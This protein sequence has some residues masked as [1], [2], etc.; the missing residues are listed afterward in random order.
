MIRLKNVSKYYSSDE[1]VTMALNN[2]NLSFNDVGFVVITGESGSGKSTLLNV[3]SGMDT[4]EDGEVYY[5]EQETSY[6]DSE[7]WD[8]YRRNNMSIIYQSYNL[9]DSY[10]ALENIEVILRMNTDLS[11]KEIRKKAYEALEKVKL[12]KQAKKRASHLSSGQ[13]QRLGIARALAKDTNVIIADEPTGNLDIEN[14]RATMEILHELSKEKL[15]LVVTHNYEQAE[16]FC[17][18]KIRLYDGKVVEDIKVNNTENIRL[19]EEKFLLGEEKNDRK[20]IFGKSVVLAGKNLMAQPHRM[21]FMFILAGFFSVASF[22]MLGTLAGATDDTMTR[23]IDTVAFKNVVKERILIKR[24]DEKEITLE[25]IETL[26]GISHIKEV[27]LYDN[28][29]DINYYYRK[30]EDYV[31]SYSYK[32]FADANKMS[33]E[34]L[35]SD[36]FVRSSY[37]I[38]EE[39][40]RSGTLPKEYNEVVMYAKDDSMLGQYIDIYFSNSK[41]GR[42]EFVCVT[43]KVTGI[44]KE[45]TEQIY[46]S[47]KLVYGLNLN[48]EKFDATLY[49]NH[50]R[51]RQYDSEDKEDYVFERE[52]KISGNFVINDELEDYEIKI[53]RNYFYELYSGDDEK[54]TEKFDENASLYA[55]ITINARNREYDEKTYDFKLS[56]SGANV[57]EDIME[58]NY[59]TFVEIT[60]GEAITQCSVYL[61]DYAYTKDALKDIEKAGYEGLSV[62]SISAMEYNEELLNQ[63]LMTLLI[64]GI[65]LVIL[66][67]LMIVVI[68]GMLRIK[69]KDLIVLRG[70]GVKKNIINKSNYCYMTILA[71]AAMSITLTALTVLSIYGV[72]TVK[73]CTKYMTAVYYMVWAVLCV[74]VNILAAVLFNR[75]LN[76]RFN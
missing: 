20:K 49:I 37:C 52:R 40:L 24:S 67:V 5:G 38:K 26:Q 70:L 19:N 44:L 35:K 60:G 28:A 25:D 29:A 68:Y 9:I 69:T 16:P 8:N 23:E 39:D 3:I 71:M 12:T 51:V 32:E 57:S 6:F 27:D 42:E 13:K 56:Q 55:S 53:S 59:D 46:F 64:S 34:F 30:N 61:E 18:R 33:V 45:K 2:I 47:K 50:I 21:M 58:V 66:F 63:R 74:L 14:G 62:F 22:L 10:T 7:D 31:V 73:N 72:E 75:T 4:Y 11:K 1:N 15:V 48:L 76:K 65:S 41:W 43:A 36:N 17:D 54:L